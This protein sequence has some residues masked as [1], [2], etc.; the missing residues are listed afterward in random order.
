M[1]LRQ[2]TEADIGYIATMVMQ[3]QRELPEDLRF[4]QGTAADAERAAVI[5]ATAPHVLTKLAVKDDG[6][7]MGGYSIIITRG[8][9]SHVPYGQML[10]WY[11][12]P[13]HRGH[14]MVGGKMLMD[15]MAETN[16]RG[17]SRLEVNPWHMDQGTKA[18]L[19]RLQFV[20]ACTTYMRQVQ[21]G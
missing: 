2:A 4:F 1:K 7:L 11:V 15:A 16:E 6:T 17:L 13:Q 21:H 20:P 3:W 18:V 9:F 5:L 19:E 10:C 8:V 12:E 14:A